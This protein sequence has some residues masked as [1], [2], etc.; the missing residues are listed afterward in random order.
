MASCAWAEMAGTRHRGVAA[1]MKRLW[2]AYVRAGNFKERALRAIMPSRMHFVHY[3]WPLRPNVCPCDLHFCDF[4]KERAIRRRSIFHFGT[5]GHHIVGL[6]NQDAGLENDVLAVTA[7][8]AEH[9]QYVTRIIRAPSLGKHYKVLFADIYNLSAAGLPTFDLVTLF[10]LCEFSEPGSTGRRMNDIE[11]LDLLLSKVAPD[12]RLFFYSGSFAR[13]QAAPLIEGAVAD[14]RMSLVETYK[15]LLV[16]R[17]PTNPVT[18]R[19]SASL[20]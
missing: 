1:V 14:G 13:R 9:A 5:G 8:P 7:S 3:S 2:N 10:H 6:Q 11:L 16:Y 18:A 15:S 20:T 17:V 12:G 4:L 19:E